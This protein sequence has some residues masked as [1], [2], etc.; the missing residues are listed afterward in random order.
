MKVIKYLGKMFPDNDK[1]GLKFQYVLCECLDCKK[2][3]KAKKYHN[4]KNGSLVC[5]ECGIRKSKIKHGLSYEKLYS[6]WTDMNARCYKTKSKGYK[7]CG[8]KGTIVCTEWK[9]D[10]LSFRNWALSNG[11]K[12]GLTIERIDGNKNYEP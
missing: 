9:N 6:V 2:Y 5:R 1:R 12:E 11:Y 8:I 10:Y 7:Y 3:I 4:S